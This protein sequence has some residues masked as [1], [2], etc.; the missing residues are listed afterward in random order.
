M[1]DWGDARWQP[2]GSRGAGLSG[3][4]CPLPVMAALGQGKRVRSGAGTGLRGEECRRNVSERGSSIKSLKR[5]LAAKRGV[6]I[7]GVAGGQELRER[8]LLLY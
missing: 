6:L 7:S 5:P 8:G 4:E 2:V 3:R 1:S